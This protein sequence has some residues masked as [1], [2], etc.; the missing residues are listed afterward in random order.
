MVSQIL[1]F[2]SGSFRY[3]PS[4]FNDLHVQLFEKPNSAKFN[5]TKVFHIQKVKFKFW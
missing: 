4:C 3:F 1:L 2:F 5:V